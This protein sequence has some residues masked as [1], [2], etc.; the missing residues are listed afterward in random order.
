MPE[1]LEAQA[2]DI[3]ERMKFRTISQVM[4]L[5]GWC[6][7]DSRTPPTIPQLKKQAEVMLQTAIQAPAE[8]ERYVAE[9]GGFRVERYRG[10]LELMFVVTGWDGR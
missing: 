2:A 4:I 10:V 7:N 9:M 8:L 3:L 5:L 1:P 6:W